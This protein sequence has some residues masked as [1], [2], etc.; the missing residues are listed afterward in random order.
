MIYL[1][2]SCASAY[3]LFALTRALAEAVILLG[4]AIGHFADRRYLRGLAERQAA[5][6]KKGYVVD[7]ESF[8]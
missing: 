3:L 2:S 8:S 7:T 6:L 1:I 5:A 4:L